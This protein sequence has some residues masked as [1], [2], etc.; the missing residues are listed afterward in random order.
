MN[1]SIFVN[2]I[3]F[4]Y[5]YLNS[6]HLRTRKLLYSLI[7]F[8]FIKA[9]NP[10]IL[11]LLITNWIQVSSDCI[12][13]FVIVEKFKKSTTVWQEIRIIFFIIN[14]QL[15]LSLMNCL[16]SIY[17]KI[18]IIMKLIK[19]LIEAPMIPKLGIKITFKNKLINPP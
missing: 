11:F 7:Y 15:I 19:L 6:I 10:S 3:Q 1:T 4:F 13:K 8:F 12:S 9:N 18:N 16:V 2:S 14:F 5:T 17:L